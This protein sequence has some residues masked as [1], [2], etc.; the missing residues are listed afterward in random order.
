MIHYAHVMGGEAGVCQKRTFD[1]QVG[2]GQNIL[3]LMI[4]F[5]N[6]P[7]C[8]YLVN[9]PVQLFQTIKCLTISST[10]CVCNTLDN[11]IYPGCQTHLTSG[12]ISVE[13]V[14]I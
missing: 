1:D 6:S 13:I 4:L 9:H 2:G 3:E 14:I 7:K 8:P 11:S 5:L 12:P 10:I